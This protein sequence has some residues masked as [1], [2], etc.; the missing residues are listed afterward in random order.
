[1]AAKGLIPHAFSFHAMHLVQQCVSRV[2]QGH[3]P[4]WHVKYATHYLQAGRGSLPAASVWIQLERRLAAG[5]PQPEQHCCQQAA[6][7]C[8]SSTWLCTCVQG[9]S[10]IGC[11]PARDAGRA[12]DAAMRPSCSLS[13]RP[14]TLPSYRGPK[15]GVNQS[16]GCWLCNIAQK[17]RAPQVDSPEE[18]GGWGIPK[19]SGSTHLAYHCQRWVPRLVHQP[20]H[21]NSVSPQSLLMRVDDGATARPIPRGRG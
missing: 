6:W 5:F 10:P 17:G 19:H 8:T 20:H 4:H 9:Y 7:L 21:A 2:H 18:G 14:R 15:F 16:T 12:S 1:M 11:R 13:Q 3:A